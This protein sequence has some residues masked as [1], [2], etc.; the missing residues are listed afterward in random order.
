MSQKSS[1]GKRRKNSWFWELFLNNK[2]VTTLLIILLILIII[3]LFGQISHYFQPLGVIVNLLAFPVITSGILYYLF[4]P[5]VNKLS[6]NGVNKKVSVFAIFIGIV[7]LVTW[8]IITLIPIIR[9]QTQSF[10]NN[11]PSYYDSISNMIANFP[12]NFGL[13]DSFDGIIEYIN[14]IDITSLTERLNPLLTSTVGGLGNVI[15]IVAQIFTGLLTIPIILYYLLV[16]GHKIPTFILYYVPNKYRPAVSR[17]M[18]QGNYQISQYI[19]GQ[20]LVAIAVGV[21]FGI[22]YSIIGLDYGVT[23][24]VLAAILNVIP[25]L[26]SIIAV[27]PALII[28]LLTSPTMLIKV[29]IVMIIEQTIEGRFIQPQILGNS[30]K[31]HPITILFILLISGRL[32]GLSGVILGVPGYAVIKVIISEIYEWYRENSDLYDDPYVPPLVSEVDN[33]LAVDMSSPDEKDTDDSQ[34]HYSPNNIS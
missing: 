31:I 25:Y 20:I 28:G 32:F 16:S 10:I 18:Y 12:F 9:D 29:I 15:G 27:I 3:W 14:Q 23:L 1:D 8:G 24:A 13:S 22:G 4:S 6:L 17:M 21:M 19:R 26:G 7:L 34:N 30:L 5:L 33:E 11:L 2:I